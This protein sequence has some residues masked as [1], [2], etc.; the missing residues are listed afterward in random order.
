MPDYTVVVSSLTTIKNGIPKYLADLEVRF[1]SEGKVC[2]RS[3]RNGTAAEKQ[4]CVC[5]LV[6]LARPDLTVLYIFFQMSILWRKLTSALAINI[7]WSSKQR[8]GVAVNMTLGEWVC[9][10]HHL[11]SA[12]V[13]VTDHKTGDKEPATVVLDEELE[14]WMDR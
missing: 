9:R 7:L 13:T 3:E 14:E 8:S 2:V 1:G 5:L 4:V 10:K 6:L 11:A 12:V